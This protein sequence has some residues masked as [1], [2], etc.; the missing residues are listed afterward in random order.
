M[1]L[2]RD[3]TKDLQSDTNRAQKKKRKKKETFKNGVYNWPRTHYT[4]GLN[5]H[6][7]RTCVRA[8]TNKVDYR[9]SLI[10]YLLLVVDFDLH[11]RRIPF[12]STHST[13]E[14]Q[15]TSN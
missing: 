5:N 4:H 11:A 15:T 3:Q 12:P 13:R 10:T 8:S 1:P 9:L 6:Y 2:S 14:T 7:V